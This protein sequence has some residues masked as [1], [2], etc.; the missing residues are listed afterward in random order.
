MFFPWRSGNQTAWRAEGPEFVSG[1]TYFV[2][3]G[4]NGLTKA[5]APLVLK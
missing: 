3:P 4:L 5:A 1:R 2:K